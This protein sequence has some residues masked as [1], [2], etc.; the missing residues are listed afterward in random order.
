MNEMQKRK[1]CGTL[2]LSVRI[3]L[4]RIARV[5]PWVHVNR[6]FV[7]VAFPQKSDEFARDD[8]SATAFNAR[9]I[10]PAL[11][12]CHKAIG[13]SPTAIDSVKPNSFLRSSLVAVREVP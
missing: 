2:F 6:I 7:A 4:H 9:T 5:A 12:C 1:G 11:S 8:V 3:P 13:S 10:G